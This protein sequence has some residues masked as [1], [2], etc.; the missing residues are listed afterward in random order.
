MSL[1]RL[2]YVAEWE[3]A[4][5]RGEAKHQ[6]AHLGMLWFG[7]FH[8][9]PITRPNGHVNGVRWREGGYEVLNTINVPIGVRYWCSMEWEG[10][11]Y[12]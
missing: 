11:E 8:Q 1:Y 9:A 5:V 3:E 6:C 12:Q 7:S 10:A 4:G 2:I